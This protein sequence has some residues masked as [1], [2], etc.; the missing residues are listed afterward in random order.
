MLDTDRCRPGSKQSDRVRRSVAEERWRE[1]RLLE[2]LDAALL[3]ASLD[4]ELAPAANDVERP[5]NQR[6][7]FF[8]CQPKHV[9]L[10]QDVVDARGSNEAADLQSQVAT[11]RETSGT[12]RMS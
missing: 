12:S 10:R 5:I 1:H 2:H 4:E 9:A 8:L 11:F 3:D 7:C 6:L